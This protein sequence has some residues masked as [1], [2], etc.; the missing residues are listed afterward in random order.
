MGESKIL[1]FTSALGC[2]LTQIVNYNPLT[3]CTFA[4]EIKLIIPWPK[5]SDKFVQQGVLKEY[6]EIFS[7]SHLIRLLS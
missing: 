3:L 5:Q 1:V 7:S 2:T 6:H 4:P